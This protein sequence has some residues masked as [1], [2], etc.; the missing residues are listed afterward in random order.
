MHHATVH[1][2]ERLLI[3]FASRHDRTARHVAAAQCLRQGDDVRLEIPMLKAE[4][5]AGPAETGLYLVRDK[6]RSVLSAKFLRTHKKIRLGRLAALALHRLDHERGDIAW[7][8]R[9]STRL[10]SSH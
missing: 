5:F 7:T 1:S 2:T 10:N 9:K 4:H 6:Q 8:D 3:N